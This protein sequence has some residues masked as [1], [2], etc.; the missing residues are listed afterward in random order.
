MIR[1]SWH[2]ILLCLLVLLHTS[3]M[4]AQPKAWGYLGWWLPQSWQQLPL[5]QL[6]R[7]LFFDL[8]VNADGAIVDRHGWPEQ[9]A[10]L[11]KSVQQN[12]VPLDLVL[13]LFEPDD[14]NRLFASVDA[15]KQLV[16]EATTLAG[17]S[18]VAGLQIDFEIYDLAQ[19][20]PI[21]NFRT[22]LR[23]LS[24][25]LRQMN[26]P[27]NLSVFFPVS[28][29]PSLYDADALKIADQV[30]LQGYDVH[31]RASKAAGPV[32]PLKG[33]DNWHWEKMVARGET[34]GVAREKM[35]L[36]FPLY[37]YEWQVKGNK[38]RSATLGS[39]VATSFYPISTEFRG[40]MQFSIQDRVR[41]YGA[42]H[43]PISGSSYYQ[44]I[45]G[46][47]QFVEGWFE[48]WWSLG[49]KSEYLT[50]EKIGGIA[51]FLIG[52]DDGQLVRFFLQERKPYSQPEKSVPKSGDSPTAPDV[53]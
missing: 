29:E 19:P 20:Q 41:Q 40:E 50:V 15:M 53:R 46:D 37:G 30:V 1:R 52:Y 27:R 24:G 33:S 38:P 21:E 10:D 7:L 48:D 9:W 5:K 28:A 8:K 51:F 6:D 44:F 18:G 2:L 22:F 35:L 42:T 4:A 14:F 3:A 12:Q 36:G 13:T 32:A 26:P 31:W 23:M 47:G 45:N 17:N 49:K 43:D 25:Q 39:G 34:L 16:S 11:Q